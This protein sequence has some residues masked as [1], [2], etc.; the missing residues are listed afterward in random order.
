MHPLTPIQMEYNFIEYDIENIV[1]TI[2]FMQ[3]SQC[4]DSQFSNCVVSLVKWS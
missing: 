3:N 2:N 4:V 1:S